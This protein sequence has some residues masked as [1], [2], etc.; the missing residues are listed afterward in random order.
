M[1][2]VIACIPV[3]ISSA[4]SATTR[5]ASERAQGADVGRFQLF[6]GR[7][8]VTSRRKD[9]SVAVAPQEGIFKIDT[10]TGQTWVYFKA[11]IEDERIISDWEPIGPQPPQKNPLVEFF[12][13]GKSGAK[14]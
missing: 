4:P 5:P 1:L 6:Q 9:N 2:I 8:S 3:C 12:L 7:Y 11:I 14:Q 13:E 10:V